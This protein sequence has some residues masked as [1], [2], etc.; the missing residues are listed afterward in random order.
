MSMTGLA[1]L[2]L[3]LVVIDSKLIWED[4]LYQKKQICDRICKNCHEDSVEDEIHFVL[5]C[6]KFIQQQSDLVHPTPA[7]LEFVWQANSDL[8]PS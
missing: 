6:S 4:I 2:D 1:W 3:E 7:V 8:V 5:D